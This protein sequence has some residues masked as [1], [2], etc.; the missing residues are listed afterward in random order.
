MHMPKRGREREESSIVK[1]FIRE[2]F[3][4]RSILSIGCIRLFVLLLLYLSFFSV[5]AAS[6]FPLLPESGIRS[7]SFRTKFR[8]KGVQRQ[9]KSE[10]LNVSLCV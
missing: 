8:A 3:I 9:R 5:G 4:T 2:M 7:D 1:D 6:S 10:R